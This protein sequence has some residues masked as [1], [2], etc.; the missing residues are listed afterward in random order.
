MYNSRLILLLF[1]CCI[2]L[3]NIDMYSKRLYEYFKLRRRPKILDIEFKTWYDSTSCTGRIRVSLVKNLAAKFPE[4]M[5]RGTGTRYV[6]P[7]FEKQRDI[8]SI[9]L[10]LVPLTSGSFKWNITGT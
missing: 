1:I 8:G 5:E 9:Q 2:F 6:V 7:H 4:R 3:L 10:Q